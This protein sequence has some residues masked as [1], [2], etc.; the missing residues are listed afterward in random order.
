MAKSKNPGG[1]VSEWGCITNLPTVKAPPNNSGNASNDKGE[2]KGNNVP[3]A[4]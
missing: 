3:K 4:K 2:V 1:T